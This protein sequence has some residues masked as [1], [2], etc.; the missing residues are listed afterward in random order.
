MHVDEVLAKLHSL[1]RVHEVDVAVGVARTSHQF[2]LC[3]IGDV[4]RSCL[5]L[6]RGDNDDAIG[7]T[8]AI[9]SRGG[10]I[11]Q[12]VH[13]LDVLGIDARDGIADI[14]DIVGV[15][16]L[17]G[18]HVDRVGQ[19]HSVEHPQ[20]FSVAD[21]GRRASHTDAR[22]GSH[23]TGVLCEH[24]VGHTSVEGIRERGHARLQDVFHLERCHGTGVL[25][26]VDVAIAR[27]HDLLY[28]V[29]VFSHDNLQTFAAPCHLLALH[30]KIGHHDAGFLESVGQ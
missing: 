21:K 24:H 3:G 8:R 6:L 7:S 19:L 4:R 18:S 11:L 30:A 14:V 20:R 27:H 13:T 10:S 9:E 16:E 17:F 1:L 2:Q 25:A 12:D 5:T 28:L 23:L 26:R 15:V 22:R 29:A